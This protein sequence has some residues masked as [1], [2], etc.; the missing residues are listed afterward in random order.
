MIAGGIS[1]LA[2]SGVK[3]AMRARPREL[4]RRCRDELCQDGDQRAGDAR[5]EHRE[6]CGRPRQSGVAEKLFDQSVR[7]AKLTK[8]DTPEV[9]DV[10]NT[11]AA[12]RFTAEQLPMLFAAY[13][14]VA[15][16]R[17]EAPRGAV[18]SA[19]AH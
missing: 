4:Q 8:F 5:A 15:G 19:S 7:I 12:N 11:L 13:G 1:G 17:P 6:F 16:A 18:P 2:V 9:V 3:M 10:M 14:D